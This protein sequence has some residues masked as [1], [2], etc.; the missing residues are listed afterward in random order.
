MH[1][2]ESLIEP[3]AALTVTPAAAAR[4]SYGG[5][6]GLPDGTDWPT[7]GGA[8]MTL[9]AHLDCADL[10]ALLPETWTLPATGALLFFHEDAFTAGSAW[11]GDPGHDDGCLVLHV[12]AGLPPRPAPT[13]VQVIPPLPLAA[14]RIGSVPPYDAPALRDAFTTD[15]VAAMNARDLAED[16]AGRPPRHQ[17]LGWQRD[18]FLHL[19]GLRPLLQLEAEPGTSWGEVVNVSFWLPEADLTTGRLTDARRYLETA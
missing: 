18:A 3:A 13:G 9:L 14:N 8:P 17:V 10:A 4:H 7:Y 2:F 1:L 6:P 16:T 5:L 19:P 15:P 12:P 11:H